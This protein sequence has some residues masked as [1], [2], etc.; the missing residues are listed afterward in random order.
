V[1]Q[2]LERLSHFLHKPAHEWS[3]SFYVRWRRV[4][5]DLS[6]P[7]LLPI[8]VWWIARNDYIGSTISY[9]GFDLPERLLLKRLLRPGSTVLD[10]GAHNGFYALFF[11]KLVGAK[12]RVIALEPSPRERKGL[13]LNLRINRITNVS[14]Q[15]VAVGAEQG[16]ATLHLADKLETGCNSLRRAP[17]VKSL[18]TVQVLVT[19]LDDLV[20]KLGIREVDFIKIDVEGAELS[21][22]QGA[23]ELLKRYPR[24]LILAEVE[25]RRTEP[26]GYP[27]REIVRAL[28]DVD[29]DWFSIKDDGHLLPLDGQVTAFEANLLAIP[30]ERR[31]EILQ[32]LA[33]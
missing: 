19:T 17:S 30:R 21:A 24:P 10:V 22:L 8:G 13:R 7:V 29:F 2:Y 3:R 32:R 5:P 6:V 1:S 33:E 16:E 23:T 20:A 12:G 11:S 15:P 14:I 25:D 4:W 9:D 27:A 26:W 28:R 18:A 31:N